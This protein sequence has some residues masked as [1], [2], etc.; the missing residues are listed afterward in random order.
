MSRLGISLILALLIISVGFVSACLS[1]TPA[2]IVSISQEQAINTA[3]ETL[4]ISIVTRSEIRAELHGW[5][6]EVI[7]D[8]VN[9]T[10]G[11]L[12]PMPLKPPLQGPT[13]TSPGKCE[14][15]PEAN[16]EVFRSVVITVD[17]QTG[18]VL[19]ASAQKAPRPGPYVS[20]EQ[21]IASAREYAERIPDDLRWLGRARIEAYLRGDIWFVLFW[22]EDSATEN[23]ISVSVD[24]GTGAVTG[25]TRQ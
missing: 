13:S 5:Y 17:A 18:V 14:F 19:S 23:R 10:Y 1:S 12:T 8:N 3:A 21:A 11:E 15:I 22:E 9:A 2:K 7:F 16:E 4:P 6:W 25:A 20:Q 24:A